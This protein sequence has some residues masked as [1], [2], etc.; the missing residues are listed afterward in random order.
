[1]HAVSVPL[2]GNDRNTGVEGL[3]GDQCR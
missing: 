3:L 1:V 2:L